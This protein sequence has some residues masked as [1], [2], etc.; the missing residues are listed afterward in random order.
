M[1]PRSTRRLILHSFLWLT[2]CSLAVAENESDQHWSF[3][4]VYREQPPVVNNPNWVRNEIDQF[5]LSR[6]ECQDLQPAP[7]ARRET[8][9][10]RL[11]LDLL[12]LPP[13]RQELES[14]LADERPN[15][16]ELAVDRILS[17]PH[18]GERWGR[19]WLD[20]VR[21]ADSN[22]FDSDHGRP[23]AWRYR[24]WV[25]DRLNEDMPFDQFTIEQIA[26]D[27]LPD[28]AQH[29][30]KVIATGYHRCS[31]HNTEG[32][33]DAEEDVYRR[34]M[35]RTNA[36]ATV[37]LGLTMQCAQCHDHKYED[38]SR[39]DYYRFYAFF[40]SLEED[41]MVAPLP[42]QIERFTK[43]SAEFEKIYRPLADRRQQFEDEL[44]PRM[45]KQWESSL[46]RP[47]EAE[48]TILQPQEV[49][50]SNGED[51]TV[52]EDGSVFVDGFLPNGETVYTMTAETRASLVT[53][54]RL[55]VLPDARLAANG[56]G[57]DP[58]GLFILNDVHVF[59]Q[60]R[61]PSDSAAE[62]PEYQAYP[63]SYAFASASSP[64]HPVENVLI[65][66]KRRPRGY[67]S[68][69][70]WAIQPQTGTRQFAVFELAAPV[71]SANGVR[72]KIHLTQGNEEQFRS[73]GRFRLAVTSTAPPFVTEGLRN[74]VVNILGFA[75]ESRTPA[76][77]SQLLDY[78]CK[79]H[80][81]WRTLDSAVQ[82]S[83]RSAP[84]SP[85][86]TKAR[87]A[88]EKEQPVPAH[89]LS[90]G[91]FQS[92][93]ERVQRAG[94][95]IL[96]AIPARGET[97]DRLDLARWL[98]DGRHP[99][100]ARVAVN[101]SWQHLFGRGIVHTSDDFGLRGEPPTHPELLDWL[102]DEYVRC[103]WSTKHLHRLIV[104]SSTYRQSSDPRPE[105][106]EIDPYNELVARQSRHRVEAEIVRDLALA[107]GD[108]LNRKIGGPSVVL[109]Q[110]SGQEDLAFVHG[111]PLEPTDG[112]DALR[113]GIYI[114]YQRTNPYPMLKLFNAPSTYLSCTRRQRSSP[115]TQSLTRLNHP[116]FFG[117]ALGLGERMY[118]EAAAEIRTDQGIVNQ[119]TNL[120]RIC[121]TRSPTAPELATLNDIYRTNIAFFDEHP[122]DA[123]QLVEGLTMTD[124]DANAAELAT[125]VTL[126]R[127]VLN[128][129]EFI[130]RE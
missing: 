60:P 99:L 98:V 53:A 120:Y 81:V 27:L 89:D 108:V 93:G 103:G 17:S 67:H 87:I 75:P 74:N 2:V 69:Q 111:D 82:G 45:M 18:Y 25:V 96:P 80:P 29:P 44:A 107:V 7:P 121:L 62:A 54:V 13:H 128:L 55:E 112:P 65:P 49:D 39:L 95:A 70:G 83:L 10:R 35:D 24:H 31:L 47:A 42:I 105:L 56:P 84:P 43:E 20:Q 51:F 109:A 58:E 73:I 64:K 116:V 11:H 9:L 15:A 78:F 21:Y 16:Y 126:A 123:R 61:Q 38:I 34:A 91:D 41:E 6:L 124:H 118:R 125:W 12:G 92:P 37:W 102:A 88:Y 3:Q 127:T 52:S 110:P 5:I 86:G 8:L 113:R 32:G 50:G 40:N 85:F 71:A 22:G 59:A 94:P 90:G 117:C 33:A 57:R 23:H 48:W 63:L 76:Q 77:Q 19:H 104:T 14:F 130:V 28:A 119:L 4:P 26:A 30:E 101:R 114:W 122:Q 68:N 79:Q 1:P 46:Q 129:E 115:P 106:E 36:T 100:T 66:N 97:P 72:L